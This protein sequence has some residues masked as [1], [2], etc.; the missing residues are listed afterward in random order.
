MDKHVPKRANQGLFRVANHGLARLVRS[1]VELDHPRVPRSV[2]GGIAPL[3]GGELRWFRRQA[4][5]K[6]TH[7]KPD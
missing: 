7:A 1:S 6:D 5:S 4:R 2:L 3:Q